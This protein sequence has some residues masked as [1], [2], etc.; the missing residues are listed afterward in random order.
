MKIIQT[1]LIAMAIAAGLTGGASAYV[2]GDDYTAV[3]STAES[4]TGDIQFDDFSITFANGKTLEFAEL[5]ADHFIVGGKTVPASVYSV[6][7]P[8]DPVLENGN[9]L[10]GSGKVSYVAAWNT[11][12]DLTALAVFTG[13]EAPASDEEMCAS[14]TYENR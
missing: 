7:K 3:S 9:R 2:E 14:Y 4:V 12:D 11:G 5:I 13:D 1:G 8:A 10:C 6:S